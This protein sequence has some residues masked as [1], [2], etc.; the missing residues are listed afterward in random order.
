MSTRGKPPGLPKSGG[1]TKGCL[2]REKR[3]EITERMAGDILSCYAALGGLTWLLQW[4]TANENEF[5]RQ[6]LSRLFPAPLKGDPEQPDTV[7]N[8]NM[9]DPL[10]V[11]MRVAFALA[12]A[13]HMLDEQQPTAERLLPLEYPPP[14]SD[15]AQLDPERERWASD[16]QLSDEQR[17]DQ[18]VVRQTNEG[19]LE[20]YPGSAA[21]QGFRRRELL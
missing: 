8:V 10:A 13:Q 9:D 11:G 15:A 21:E 12:K 18:A 5:V 14:L 4:A 1:R 19:S 7:V 3:L 2:N 6:C 16:L 20:T 17:R